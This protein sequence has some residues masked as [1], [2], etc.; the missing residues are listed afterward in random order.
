MCVRI[1]PQVR[2][3]G[4]PV[5]LCAECDYVM[6]EALN[7]RDAHAL[8]PLMVIPTFTCF[9]SALLVLVQKYKNRR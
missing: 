7:A 3:D 2:E 4:A 9:T 1:L 5:W 8:T 6:Q